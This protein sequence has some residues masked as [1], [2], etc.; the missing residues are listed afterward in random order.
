MNADFRR[1]LIVG[2]HKDKIEF[3]K[4]FLFGYTSVQF[5]EICRKEEKILI[6]LRHCSEYQCR[7]HHEHGKNIT[8][9]SFWFPSGLILEAD[10]NSDKQWLDSSLADSCGMVLF[11]FSYPWKTAGFLENLHMIPKHL[12]DNTFCH[13]VQYCV[14]RWINPNQQFGATDLVNPE[15]IIA[16]LPNEIDKNLKLSAETAFLASALEYPIYRNRQDFWK[17]I[18]SSGKMQIFLEEEARKNF[19]K[20]HQKIEDFPAEYF[21][22]HP[23]YLGL[24]VYDF[25]LDL[26]ER[27][28]NLTNQ[29]TFR[30]LTTFSAVQGSRNIMYQYRD[31]Y[32]QRYADIILR[33]A[34]EIYKSNIHEICFWNLEKDIANLN[35][36][37]EKNYQN[38]FKNETIVACPN[39]QREYQNILH[40][41]KCDIHFIEK[42]VYFINNGMMR[43]IYEHILK[44][45]KILS[46]FL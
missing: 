3:I 18:S 12:E 26:Q 6:Y 37:I 40:K 10:M 28:E 11:L 24:Y 45:E 36:E 22:E 19:E 42:T 14:I 2:E 33:V 20:W 32:Y 16:E 46:P 39:T 34:D 13:P 31:N 30:R 21:S 23:D 1:I 35:L 29:E 38:I 44:K 7:I 8:I 27:F 5:E 4:E 25:P 43:I 17:I 41:T 15:K 9:D